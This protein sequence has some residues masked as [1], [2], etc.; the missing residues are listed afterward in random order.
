LLLSYKLVVD[1]TTDTI[2]EYWLSFSR[3]FST[4]ELEKNIIY[5]TYHA[6]PNVENRQKKVVLRKGKTVAPLDLYIIPFL[7]SRLFGTP[8]NVSVA[9]HKL[10]ELDFP[11]FPVLPTKFYL[12]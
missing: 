12:G 11:L 4:A 3:T 7:K 5:Y 10:E 2:S 1:T 9:K 8:I 6:I